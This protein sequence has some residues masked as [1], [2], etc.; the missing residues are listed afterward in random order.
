MGWLLTFF[1]SSQRRRS[2]PCRCHTG[3]SNFIASACFSWSFA[4]PHTLSP[5][6]S[7]GPRNVAPHGVPWLSLDLRP[8]LSRQKRR[9]RQTNSWGRSDWDEGLPRKTGHAQNHRRP[10]LTM[11]EKMNGG[12]YWGRDSSDWRYSWLC[13]RF[14]VFSFPGVLVVWPGHSHTPA[15]E[16]MPIAELM[17]S[18][19]CSALYAT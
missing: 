16:E 9:P 17:P 7:F 15:R 4:S 13:R 14:C 6:A 19:S 2:S 5:S 8:N 1:F 11:E 10:D 12:S 3:S 18:Q